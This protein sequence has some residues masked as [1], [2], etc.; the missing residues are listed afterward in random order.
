MLSPVELC[1]ATIKRATLNNAGDIER[2]GLC[3]NCDVYVRRSNDVIPE[4]LGIAERF[5][6]SVPVEKAEFCPSCGARLE[7]R[8]ANLF[9]PNRSDCPKQVEGRL[10]H[11]CSKNGFDIEGIRDKTARQFMNIGVRSPADLF[12]LDEEKIKTLDKFKDK[13]A[14]KLVDAIKKSKDVKLANFIYALGIDNVGS[15]TAKELAEKFGSVDALRA[16]TKE[17]LL[18]IDDVGEIVAESI[19]EW[20]SEPFNGALTDRLKAEGID[21]HYENKTVRGAFSGKRVVLTGSL[22]NFTRSK[23]SELIEERGGTVSSS[24]SASTDLVIA[25][26]E[27]GSKLEKAEKLGIEII[28]ENKFIEML[29]SN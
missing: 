18:E 29:Q 7:E 16:A 15:V 24:V 28:D 10:T 21:P 22:E 6:D 13:K 17:Q 1:G 20:F 19:T 25:G 23:A 11:F 27:A 3:V 8:G 4:V 5:P 12:S 26:S 9:C 2:K 14:S